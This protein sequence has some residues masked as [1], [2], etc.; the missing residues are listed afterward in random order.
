MWLHTLK[1]QTITHTASPHPPRTD[2]TSP[3]RADP[4]FLTHFTAK[5][6]PSILNSQHLACEMLTRMYVILTR[7]GLLFIYKMIHEIVSM[8]RADSGY[9]HNFMV[10]SWV[11]KDDESKS[12][13]KTNSVPWVC[14]FLVE[15]PHFACAEHAQCLLL[16]HCVKTH[17]HRYE[18]CL[19]P[20]LFSL[21]E[22][23]KIRESFAMVSCFRAFYYNY[24]T[25]NY[26]I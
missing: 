26:R 14:P 5:S 22:M 19:G 1:I 7:S 8:P 9:F 3:P 6:G 24:F 23:M 13:A 12:E 10:K 2:V 25:S 20:I 18:S 17:T 15:G 21:Y 16:A 11:F 4:N